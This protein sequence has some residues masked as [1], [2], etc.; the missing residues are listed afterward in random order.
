M[1]VAE[2]YSD[3]LAALVETFFPVLDEE[4]LQKSSH[5]T[6]SAAT[7]LQIPL[8]RFPELIS[9]VPIESPWTRR[10]YMQMC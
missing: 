6:G 7:S 1:A 2:P 4:T 8:H 5:L 3:V 10:C 9:E